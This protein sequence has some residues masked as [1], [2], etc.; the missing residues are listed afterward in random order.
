M[1][2]RFWPFL[3]VL[4]AV[5]FTLASFI[6]FGIDLYGWRNINAR[7]LGETVGSAI[8][9]VSIPAL[10]TGVWRAAQHLFGRPTN[11]PIEA[12]AFCF[13]SAKAKDQGRPSAFVTE[14][15]SV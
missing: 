14:N 12:G 1:A 3:L 8:A 5:A 15:K 11:A 10:I 6:N 13:W 7:V 9:L 4:L 2:Y